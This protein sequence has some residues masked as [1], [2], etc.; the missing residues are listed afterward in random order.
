MI[1]WIYKLTSTINN[2]LFY[3][4]YTTDCETREMKH[5]YNLDDTNVPSYIY[6]KLRE[7]GGRFTFEIVK[8]VAYDV[9]DELW[10]EERECILIMKPPLNVLNNPNSLKM[11]E[12]NAG[13]MTS[14]QLTR[15]RKR[16]III[17]INDLKE[18]TPRERKG[19]TVM[20]NYNHENG[21]TYKRQTIIYRDE[22]KLSDLPIYPLKDTM[23]NVI[24]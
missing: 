11:I 21:N 20:G 9:I 7:V 3:I 5:N 16:K 2:E 10:C 17:F 18:N 1:G 6:I 23:G 12:S 13:R 8:E 24:M 22:I 19:M 14:K 15:D 4:G